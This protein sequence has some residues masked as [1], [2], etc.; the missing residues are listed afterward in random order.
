V[1]DLQAHDRLPERIEVTAYY[2]AAEA[3]TNAAKHSQA[4]AVH[5]A[6]AVADGDVRLAISDDGVGGADE[7]GSGLIGLK[8]RVGAAGG[9]MVVE[10]LPGKGT[11]LAVALPLGAPRSQLEP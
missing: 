3:L 11:H 10:S 5:V 7:A 6:V 4:S 2:V 9:T 8:D 1:L